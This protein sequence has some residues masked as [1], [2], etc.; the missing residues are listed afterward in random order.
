MTTGYQIKNQ[1]AMHYFT[2][3]WFSG[4]ITAEQNL[5]FPTKQK[6]IFCSEHGGIINYV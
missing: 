3:R 6:M 2:F 1:Y 4:D 5:Q